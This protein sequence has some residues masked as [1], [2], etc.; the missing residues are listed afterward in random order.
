MCS[1]S[2]RR[3]VSRAR[4]F[5]GLRFQ[6]HRR[7]KTQASKGRKASI[8]TNIAPFDDYRRIVAW[9]FGVALVSHRRAWFWTGDIQPRSAVPSCENYIWWISGG[10]SGG[11]LVGPRSLAD[12]TATG[13]F[14]IT[15]VG[16]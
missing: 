10:N 13:D 11:A 1:F 3:N 5:Y 12:S 2:I 9:E 8:S 4:I 14:D 15:L 16:S 6:H 7:N